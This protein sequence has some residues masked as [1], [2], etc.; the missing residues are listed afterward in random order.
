MNYNRAKVEEVV[1][2][3]WVDSIYFSAKMTRGQIVPL[4]IKEYEE[5]KNWVRENIVKKGHFTCLEHFTLVLP[6]SNVPTD[7]YEFGRLVNSTGWVDNNG[8]LGGVA[9]NPRLL[10]DDL[11]QI[12]GLS[13]IQAFDKM[14]EMPLYPVCNK[15]R[16]FLVTTNIG[17][18]REFNRHRRLSVLE[19]STRYVTK[20]RADETSSCYDLLKNNCYCKYQ[21]LLEFGV[22]KDEARG[23]LPLGTE[24][25]A[26]Y[27]GFKSSWDKFLG[28]RLNPDAHED[29]RAIA[30]K[31]KEL[32]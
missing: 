17:V 24:T 9:I 28:L 12:E 10:F 15:R 23:V 16:T 30:F 6:N 8:K 25:V 7:N 21:Q 20:H 1:F 32:L 31:I 14:I 11:V 5:R 18:T 2:T 26:M 3:N 13:Y 29:I 27:T 19:K 22:R 4:P